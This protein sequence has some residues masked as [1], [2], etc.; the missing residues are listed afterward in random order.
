MSRL[1]KD[2]TYSMTRH[3]I[4]GVLLIHLVSL[5]FLYFTIIDIYKNNVEEQFVGHV[6]E[7]TGLLSDFI[8][9][10][11]SID[12]ENEVVL[13][14]ESALLGGEVLYIELADEYGNRLFPDTGLTL[15]T[16]DFLKIVILVSTMTVSILYLYL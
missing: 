9:A 10:K 7:L 1:R 13:Q 4:L 8:D 14:M 16:V 3:V 11:E 15:N 6:R 12:S 2:K 5:P